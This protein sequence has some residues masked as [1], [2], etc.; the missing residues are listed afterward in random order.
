MALDFSRGTEDAQS[1]PKGPKG[2]RDPLAPQGRRRRP[3]V[4]KGA[5]GALGS[6][7]APKAPL[8]P[9]GRRR[10]PWAPQ[11][12]V[13]ALGWALGPIIVGPLGPLGP[14]GPE[15]LRAGGLEKHDTHATNSRATRTG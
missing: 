3:W 6:P 1:F 7:R 8:G 13:G 14:L 10:R 9:Q 12:P 11:G 2:Q 15:A 5:E 4:P